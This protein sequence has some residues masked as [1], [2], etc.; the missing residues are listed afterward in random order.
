MKKCY[1][2]AKSL[3]EKYLWTRISCIK[4]NKIKI[5]RNN[6]YISPEKYTVEGDW[7]NGA[8]FI[9]ADKIKSNN[10]KCNNLTLDSVQGDK[11]VAE[12]AGKLSVPDS[13]FS[14]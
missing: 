14:G 12:I 6:G 11:A 7:S 2:S 5:F 10:V 13:S 9:C 4:E 8:F 3:S 1:F